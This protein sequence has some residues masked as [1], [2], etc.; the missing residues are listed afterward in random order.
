MTKEVFCLWVDNDVEYITPP[1]VPN[2]ASV[3]LLLVF[4]LL[5]PVPCSCSVRPAQCWVCPCVPYPWGLSAPACQGMGIHPELIMGCLNSDSP[6]HNPHRGHITG[7]LA[8]SPTVH[9]SG[10]P[11]VHSAH[12]LFSLQVPYQYS[13]L[14]LWG[15]GC[16]IRPRTSGQTFPQ[17]ER[18]AFD[19]VIVYGEKA[20]VKFT[21][22]ERDR[23]SEQ[24]SVPAPAPRERSITQPCLCFSNSFWFSRK[25]WAKL[26][27]RNIHQS[28]PFL[29]LYPLCV[30][31]CA[32]LWKHFKVCVCP[33]LTAAKGA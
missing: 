31:E 29:N 9:A 12:S 28:S 5:S 17:S 19:S 10:L 21:G 3:E 25:L 6:Q 24:K 27:C 2:I 18:K 20:G 7:L 13:V 4:V 16:Q 8:P 11:L 26:K 23:E 15:G 30:C 14:F 33:I 1:I 22:W 32:S